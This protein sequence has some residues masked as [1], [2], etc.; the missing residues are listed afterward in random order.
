MSLYTYDL[1]NFFFRLGI[2]VIENHF[3][4]RGQ[5]STSAKMTLAYL[6]F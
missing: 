2:S 6:F 5:E 1:K 4:T 3:M